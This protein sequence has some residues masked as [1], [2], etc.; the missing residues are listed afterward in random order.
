MKGAGLPAG[1][2]LEQAP[3]LPNIKN[4]Q[5]KGKFPLKFIQVL[6]MPYQEPE[7]VEGFPS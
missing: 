3:Q 7:K 2:H 1:A 4:L 5:T 6:P